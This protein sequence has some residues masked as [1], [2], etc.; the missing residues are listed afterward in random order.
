MHN[1]TET[2]QLKIY[3]R[4][5]N[6]VQVSVTKWSVG[7]RFSLLQLV[8]CNFRKSLIHHPFFV[9]L[10]EGVYIWGLGGGGE[11]MCDCALNLGW[12]PVHDV[13]RR[14]CVRYVVRKMDGWMDYY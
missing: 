12:H 4:P 3:K 14:S 7:V 1:L 10:F 11:C 13:P 8:R 2:G 9:I 6:G 5:G